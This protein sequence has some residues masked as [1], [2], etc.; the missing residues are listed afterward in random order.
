L[1]SSIFDYEAGVSF[2]IRAIN[3]SSKGPD[4]WKVNASLLKRPGYKKLIE[5]TINDFCSAQYAYRDVKFWW[6]SLKYAIQIVTQ[7]YA[8]E[9]NGQ[10]KRTLTLLKGNFC[11]LTKIFAPL[12]YLAPN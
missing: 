11:Q 10:R 8:K 2:T 6:K 9:Q 7:L 3:V 5:S 1:P 12:H 4:Y